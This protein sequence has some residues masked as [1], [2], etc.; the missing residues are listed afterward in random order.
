MAIFDYEGYQQALN[1]AEADRSAAVSARNK[2]RSELQAKGVTSWRSDPQYQALTNQINQANQT[3]VILKKNSVAPG[4]ATDIDFGSNPVPPAATDSRSRLQLEQAAQQPSIQTTNVNPD[5]SKTTSSVTETPTSRTEQTITTSGG[6][7][8]TVT[9]TPTTTRTVTKTNIPDYNPTSAQKAANERL[10]NADEDLY[11]AQQ[12]KQETIDRLKAQGLSGSQVL[13]HPDYKAANN[14][15]QAANSEY[16]NA[17]QNVTSLSTPGTSTTAVNTTTNG[18]TSPTKNA[19][20]QQPVSSNDTAATLTDYHESD[21]EF[22]VFNVP[23]TVNVDDPSAFTV[24]EQERLLAEQEEGLFSRPVDDPNLFYDDS[25]GEFVPRTDRPED[26]QARDVNEFVYNDDL[27]EWVR[28]EDLP[29]N[30]RYGTEPA[31]DPIIVRDDFG[32][33]IGEEEYDDESGVCVPIAGL[34]LK[35]AP[36]TPDA[37]RDS[38]G[39]LIGLEEYDD[40]N[41]VC[42]PIG[43]VPTYAGNPVT[44]QPTPPLSIREKRNQVHVSDKSDWRFKV[45]LSPY[46]E[47]LYNDPDVKKSGSGLLAPLS[48][49]DG[50]IFPYTP[51]ITVPYQANYNSYE[52]THSNYRGFFYRGS[53]VGDIIVRGKFTAQDTAEAN[54]LLATIHFFRSCTK[55]FYGQDNERGAPPPLLYI[56]GFGDNQF[57]EQP[58]ALSYFNYEIPNDVDFV[59]AG[60]GTVVNDQFQ[61]RVSSGT[62]YQSWSSKI[63]RLITSGLERGAPPLISNLDPSIQ[64]VTKIYGGETYVPSAINLQLTF[65]PVQT[66]NQV[67][68]EFSFKDYA[69]GSLISKGFW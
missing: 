30:W 7:A 69:N 59:R 16:A 4:E 31:D 22:D 24:T 63:S 65:H 57:A 45:R 26:W 50:V 17:Q 48:K 61:G 44:P 51:S 33:I 40:T 10:S 1:D 39:C 60:A 6:N 8:N 21:P 55:M 29:D 20:V 14:A 41:G 66:R 32:C 27:G 47:Y 67:S 38:F 18:F 23:G 68:K 25:L 13:S 37:E 11:N 54:Y 53:Q 58:C 28:R 43:E 19:Y 2:L 3:V 56:S 15:Y 12:D 5:G 42:V 49:T 46:S 34:P 64:G 62:G 35:T 52:L 9:N 36:A